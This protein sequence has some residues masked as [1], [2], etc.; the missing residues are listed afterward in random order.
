MQAD[1]PARRKIGQYEVTAKLGEGGMG[2]VYRA[3]DAKL[4]RDVALKLLPAAL[5]HDGQSLAR[6]EREARTLA[7]LNHPNIAAIYGLEEAEGMRALVMEL[8]EGETLAEHIHGASGGGAKCLSPE[9]ALPIAKQIAE[10]LEYAHERGVIHR[11]LKPA[12]VKITPEGTVKVLDFGLAKVLSDQDSMAPSVPANSPTLSVLATQAGMIL[13]TAAYMAP[14]QAKGKQVDRRAD[15]WAFGCVLFEM[16]SGKKPFEGETISDLLAAVIRG[17]PEWTDLPE[18]T[19]PA[20]KRLIRRCLVKDPKQRLRDIGDA[21]IAIEEALSGAAPDEVAGSGSGT[22]ETAQASRMRRALPWALG[23]ATIIFAGVAAWL[24]LKPA[25]RPNVIRFPLAP[26]EGAEFI[27]GGEMSISPDGRTLAFVAAQAGPDKPPVLWLRP[28]DSMTAQAIPGTEGAEVPFWSPD[29][30]QIGFQANGKLEKIAAAGG[31]PLTLCD[32]NLPGGSWNKDGVILFY[33]HNNI[34]T[35]PD[36]GGEPTLVATPDAARG[37][38]FQLPQFLPDGRHFIVQ[39]RSGSPGGDY[40]AAGSLDSK[41]VD[42][43]TS[44]TS[45]ALYAPP[46]YLFYMDQST[47]MARPFNAK[48]LRFT[49]G[50]VPVAQNVGMYANVFYGYFSVSPAGVLAYESVPAVSTNQMTW[51][52]RTGQKL[53]AVGQPDVYATPVLSPD[54]SKLAVGVG[55]LGKHNIW[56]YDLKRGTGSRLTIDTAD[57]LNPVW[58]PDRSRVLFSSNRAGQYDIYQQAADG[59]GSTEP[60]LQSKDQ[61]K[62]L[63]DLTTDGRYAIFDNGGASNDTALWAL[64][65]FG[66]H[67]PFPFVGGGLRAFSA[68]FSPNGR[69]LAYSSTETGRNEIYVQ[70]FPQQTGKWQISASGGTEPMWR[71]DGKELYFLAPD[72]K[73]MA[74]DVNTNTGTFQADIPKELFQAQVIPPWYWRNIYVPSA[75]GQRFLMLTPAID[76]KPSPITVVVNWTAMLKK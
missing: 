27:D 9:E 1:P 16:L 28:L 57:D 58:S 47:L 3:R 52:N 65:L 14:E 5:A 53:G 21:R 55:A 38:F 39:V 73:L 36:T 46:G 60:V 31:T 71:R 44:A 69:Y 45:N 12:N 70:T 59:L 2:E 22:T 43:L 17:E 8:V 50:A 29:S 37:E 67:K 51:F 30:Q 35:V 64:P 11:D 7:A 33:N 6:L 19:P 76:A 25:P 10:A 18:K 23:V 72:Q 20:I 62:Y 66:D 68:Q 42:R 61:V 40:I 54:G 75:D 74:V 49:G 4:G 26:P 56:V 63:N 41:T 24:L 15:I 34:Y 48:A 32:E 13:G